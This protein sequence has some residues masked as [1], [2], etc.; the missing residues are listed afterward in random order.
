L[1]KKQIALFA[2]TNV[3]SIIA[4]FL[5]KVAA[6]ISIYFIFVRIVSQKLTRVPFAALSLLKRETLFLLTHFRIGR[7]QF[8]FCKYMD[9]IFCAAQFATNFIINTQSKP[10]KLLTVVFIDMRDF[11]FMQ[12][13]SDKVTRETNLKRESYENSCAK[14]LKIPSKWGNLLML[15]AFF[16]FVNRFAVNFVAGQPLDRV[17]RQ[18]MPLIPQYPPKVDSILPTQKSIGD[19]SF[20]LSL[21]GGVL[22][23]HGAYTIGIVGVVGV[24][25]YVT[26]L[27]TRLACC[28]VRRLNNPN[29]DRHEFEMANKLVLKI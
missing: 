11:N 2:Q 13:N 14:N 21:P 27:V 23:A 5:L 15:V 20:S 19:E 24:L 29:G 1:S 26:E 4:Y 22:T 25:L 16:C 17:A 8:I 10:S 9:Q 6:Q 28:V 7:A 3:Q 18:A 12:F